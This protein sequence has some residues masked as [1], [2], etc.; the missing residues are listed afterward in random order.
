MVTVEV[1][2]S[3]LD[4]VGASELRPARGKR[5]VFDCYWNGRL[6]PYSTIDEYVIDFL[7][8]VFTAYVF[9]RLHKCNLT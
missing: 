3:D 6:I 8:A 5:P 1:D 4:V 2:D 7:T 9:S